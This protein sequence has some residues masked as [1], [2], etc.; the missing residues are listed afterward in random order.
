MA[1]RATTATAS[2]TTTRLLRLKDVV[3]GVGLC[4]PGV[5]LGTFGYIH[6][7]DG[8]AQDAAVPVPVYMV[9]QIKMPKSAYVEAAKA[10]RYAD[11]RNG[12]AELA[13]AEARVRSGEQGASIVDQIR[14]G[15]AHQPASARGWTLLAEVLNPSQEKYAAQSLSQALILAPNDYWL[16]GA[17]AEDAAQL[18]PDLDDDARHMAFAQ[19]RLLWQEPQL[20]EQLVDLARTPAGAALISRAFGQDDIRAINRLLSRRRKP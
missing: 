20:R 16:A 17:R 6:F 11:H 2:T 19:T 8:W 5:L 4:L 18:W 13:R 14:D 1:T 3:L 7:V 12:G 9:A 15:L 10:L